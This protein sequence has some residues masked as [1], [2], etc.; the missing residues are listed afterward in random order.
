[1]FGFGK[2]KSP[3][4]EVPQKAGEAPAVLGVQIPDD[5]FTVMPR[6]YLPEV[7]APGRTIPK[8]VLVLGGGAFA[9]LAGL[10]AALYA[11]FLSPAP[12]AAPAVRPNVSQSAPAAAPSEIDRVP[13]VSETVASGQAF[14]LN[15]LLVG[16]L[17]ITIPAT[18][19]QQ[20][21][22]GIGVTVLSEGDL[23]LPGD[24][25][26][27]GGL[28]SAYPA[29]ITFE[30]P[31]SLELSV[32]SIPE[33]YQ[34]SDI[35]P[36]YLRGVQWEEFPDY[37]VT[38]AG[39]STALEKIPS[40]PI[41]VI[42]QPKAT[43]AESELSF[44]RLVPSADTDADGLTDAEE[45]LFGTSSASADSD[46]DSYLDLEEITNGYSPL[47]AGVRLS[48]AGLFATYTNATYGYRIDYPSSWLADSL[49]QTNK[50]VLFISDSEEFFEILIVENPLN[51][52]I[53]DW[54]RGQSPSLANV[55]LEVFVLDGHPSV[56][57]P[58][59]LTLYTASDGI[60]YIITYNSGTRDDISWPNVFEHFYASF[61]FG[62]NAPA[63][64]P[65]I[66]AEQ[67]GD[68]R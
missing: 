3:A 33:S 15:N 32:A 30:E 54:F 16:S 47:A 24:G 50:Q 21:G 49:D 45:T 8:K 17:T 23:A 11:V 64:A 60:I 7:S 43:E 34:R 52:P 63:A 5:T 59:G 27:L 25:T 14:D 29:G 39:F 22:A 42:W 67:A 44:T 61:A 46:G 62:V 9:A 35:F 10:F 58:D 31:L 36:A 13:E 20:Y 66:P 68:G 18:V 12:E 40:G 51:T 28:Y 55:E 65:D 38:L 4:G 48:E 57:S 37:Q 26:V 6:E 19:A 53:A 2:K 41:A 1:M 56:W